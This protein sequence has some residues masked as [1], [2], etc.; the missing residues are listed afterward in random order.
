MHPDF[1]E[2]PSAT[3]SWVQSGICHLYSASTLLFIVDITV[4]TKQVTRMH[5]SNFIVILA[6]IAFTATGPLESSGNAADLEMVDAFGNVTGIVDVSRQGISVFE[7]NG[8]RWFYR[9][10]PRYDLPGGRYLGFYNLELNRAI[11]FPINGVG[12]IERADFDSPIPRFVPATVTVRP[13]GTSPVFA[14]YLE[15]W[16]VGGIATTGTGL[17]VGPG[18]GNAFTGTTFHLP[19]PAL[20]GFVPI[21]RSPALTPGIGFAPSLFSP[22]FG[23]PRSILLESR[24]ETASPLSPVEV[25]LVN[26]QP[27]PLQ[28]TIRDVTQPGRIANYRI[29]PGEAQRVKLPRSSASVRV[30]VYQTYDLAGQPIEQEVRDPIPPTPR[31]EVVVHKIQ[32]Q[33]IAIDRTGKSPNPIEDVNMQGIGVGSFWLP[34]GEALTSG[35]VDVFTEATVAGNAGAITPIDAN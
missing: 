23:A 29:S 17:T 4:E 14:P 10:A 11:R 6:C 32:I 8:G 22:G 9:R 28:V 27:V 7:N 24:V 34:P 13:I 20:G 19:G 16:H 18:F 15:V 2:I 5:A 30:R 35:T 1:R 21:A 33:S 12:L 25:S 31:Y 26:S 3:L